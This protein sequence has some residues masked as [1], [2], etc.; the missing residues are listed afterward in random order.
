MHTKLYTEGCVGM[1]SYQFKAKNYLILIEEDTTPYACG[2]VKGK[3]IFFSLV[4]KIYHNGK[5]K[6]KKML[7][8]YSNLWTEEVDKSEIIK[9][10]YTLFGDSSYREKYRTSDYIWADIIQIEEISLPNL[11]GYLIG[12]AK[13]DLR[14]DCMLMK[15]TFKVHEKYSGENLS[16]KL[17]VLSLYISDEDIMKIKSCFKDRQSIVYA[18]SLIIQGESPDTSINKTKKVMKNTIKVV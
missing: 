18:L 16:I 5:G 7:A 11:D 2:L 13:R 3:D 8:R 17:D 14:K 4:I 6:T 15:N 10:I 12:G 9:F 1:F